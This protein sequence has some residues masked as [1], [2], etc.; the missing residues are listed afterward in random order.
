VIA[1]IAI[2]IALLL[3]AVQQAREAARRTQCK[4]N[5]KQWGLAFHNYHDTFRL[6]PM[7]EMGLNPTATSNNL[8]W[9]V[10]LLP[11]LDQA[12]LYEKF[13]F[14][15]LYN[16][17]PNQAQRDEKFEALFCPSARTRNRQ[18]ATT[19]EGW[20]VHY[21]GV[22]G[23]K[24]PRPAP[25]TGNFP[26][27]H[28]TANFN[29]NHGNMATSGVLYRNSKVGIRDILD[30]T[31]NTLMVG[32]ISGIPFNDGGN[33][34]HRAWIQGASNGNNNFASYAC[35]NVRWGIGQARYVSN[36]SNYL[37]NDQ[38]FGSN[39]EGGAQFLVGDGSVRFVSENLD[40]NLYQALATRDEG[41][42]VGEW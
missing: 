25:A 40:F 8:S 1:I 37:F 3:P 32:E 38:R 29:N 33:N 13:N 27:Q 2:L 22:A 21:Y 6:F 19:T 34:P 15:V 39:H 10:R 26:M 20:T 18:P 11:Y 30:G 7:G 31:T 36:N 41:E 28:A 5:L 14:S 23:A 35:K 12:P 17:A 16:T 42:V 9:H 4:N 24:G